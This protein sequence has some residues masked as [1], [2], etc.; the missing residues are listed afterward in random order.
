MTQWWN[1][2]LVLIMEQEDVKILREMD[3]IVKSLV[4]K[5]HPGPKSDYEN[6]MYHI[7]GYVPYS[8]YNPKEKVV[9]ARYF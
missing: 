7:R 3:F 4:A 5:K 9:V 2:S 6:K 1:D 8:D